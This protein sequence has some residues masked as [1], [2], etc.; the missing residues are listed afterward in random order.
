MRLNE[1]YYSASNIYMRLNEQYDLLLEYYHKSCH[2][3]KVIDSIIK[4]I[5]KNPHIYKDFYSG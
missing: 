5:K 2:F 1:Y 4:K 3:D